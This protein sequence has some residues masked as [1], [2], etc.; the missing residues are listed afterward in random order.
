[1]D[2]YLRGILV[3]DEDGGGSHPIHTGTVVGVP[4]NYILAKF[5]RSSCPDP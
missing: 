4:N 5:W 1:M 2:I 3:F